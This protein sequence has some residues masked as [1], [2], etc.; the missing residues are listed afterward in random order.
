MLSRS[1]VAQNALVVIAVLLSGYALYGLRGIV[2]PLVLALFLV[3]MVDGFARE[4][5]KRVPF[6]PE[7]SALPVALV[8]T[9]L[10]LGLTVYA[11]AANAAVFGAQ[12]FDA[13]PRLNAMIQGFA[14]FFHLD[15]PPTIEKLINRL[16]LGLGSAVS[17]LKNPTAPAV[18]GGS[19]ASR[20]GLCPER[21]FFSSSN[22]S[23]SKFFF[24]RPSE[25]D[26]FR[27]CATIFL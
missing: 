11:V 16:N 4:L 8:L 5:A 3:V 26:I 22:T 27:P 1:G 21:A 24:L 12:L 23:P 9:A 2:T 10:A 7:W 13:A 15:V 6:L 20:A 17:V 25:T 18:N 14:A 19:P